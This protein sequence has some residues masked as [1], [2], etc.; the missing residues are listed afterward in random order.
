MDHAEWLIIARDAWWTCV[1]TSNEDMTAGI[2]MLADKYGPEVA[3]SRNYKGFVTKRAA[4][5]PDVAECV[6]D[7]QQ[8]RMRE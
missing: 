5:L 4:Q 2:H 1:V 3:V 6:I 7:E 8:G